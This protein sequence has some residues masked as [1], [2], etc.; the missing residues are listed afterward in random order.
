MEEIVPNK[1]KSSISYKVIFIIIA[2]NIA[3]HYYGV[4]SKNDLF[5]YIF[6]IACPVAAGI[7]SLIVS[8]GYSSST[9]SKVFQR[10]F[11]CLGI[12]LF[13]TATGDFIYF[14]YDTDNSYPSIADIFYFPFYPLVITHLL[15]NIRFFKYG[16]PKV[17]LKEDRMDL[18]WLILIPSAIF[19]FY[20][21]LSDGLSYSVE[22]LLSDYYVVIVAISLSFNIYAVKIFKKGALGKPWLLLLFGILIFGVADILYYHLESIN[23]YDALNPINMLWNIGYLII[24]YSLIKHDR[25]I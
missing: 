21:F 11:F 1:I 16:F 12:A 18:A 25:I 19:A 6:S 17:L 24:L 8:K 13:F 7:A 23:S 22:T 14:I 9:T 20:I 3:V 15:L 2:A 4:L 5:V 10:G